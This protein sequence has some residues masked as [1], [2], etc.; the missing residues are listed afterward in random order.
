VRRLGAILFLASLA[1]VAVASFFAPEVKG[2]ARWID[3]GAF[4]LQP[5][6]FLK[7]GLVVVWAWM[8]SEEM[9]HPRF[10]GR[11]IALSLYLVAAA[12]LVMQPDVGQTALLGALLAALLLISGVSWRFL[13]GGALFAA[14]AGAALYH[15]EGH[16]RARIDAFLAPGET[17]YQVGRALDAFAS[18]GLF[19]RGPGEGIVKRTLPDAHSDFVYAVAAEEFGLFASLGLIA[20]FGL[21]AWRGLSRASRLIDAFSQLAATGLIALLVMQAAIHIAVNVS[22]APAKGMTLPFVSYGGSS[23]LGAAITIGLALALLRWRP[24][25]HLYDGRRG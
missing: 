24:G 12:L 21:I 6:E 1:L 8:L 14:L 7:P 4:A 19:G 3:V 22:F 20:L 5:S 9:K 13:A 2:A 16:V 10:P 11:W 25:A 23:M 18:G 17:P 15:L